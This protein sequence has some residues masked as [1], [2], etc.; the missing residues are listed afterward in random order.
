MKV[1]ST[2]LSGIVLLSGVTKV[3]SQQYVDGSGS[4]AGNTPCH[5]TIQSAITSAAAGEA[6]TVYPGTYAE[7]VTINKNITLISTGGRA[8]TTISGVQTSPAP[9]I[10]G[11]I[12]L[13]GNTTGVSIGT[14]TANGFTI[15]GVDWP[16]N[17]TDVGAIYVQ[18]P[19]TQANLSIIGNDVQAKGDNGFISEPG[20]TF[21]GFTFDNNILSGQTFLGTQPNQSCCSSACYFDNT[22]SNV[23]RSLFVLN[24]R[25]D[26]STPAATNVRFTDNSITGIAGANA[27][28]NI[29]VQIA[30]ADAIIEKNVFAGTTVS[31]S[32][33]C[34]RGTLRVRGTNVTIDCNQFNSAGLTG[35][36]AYH[37]LFDKQNSYATAISPANTLAGVAQYNNYDANPVAFYNPIGGLCPAIQ[38][39]VFVNA[40][41]AG[42][43]AACGGTLQTV[44]GSCVKPL[45]VTLVS[46]SSTVI[47][48]AVE[49]SWKTTSEVNNKYFEVERSEEGKIF[50]SLGQLEGK[51]TTNGINSYTFTDEQPNVG[52]NYYRLKQVDFDGAKTY[53]RMLAVNFY[54]SDFVSVYPNP[55]TNQVSVQFR[56]TA[57]DASMSVSNM[58]LYNQNGQM[59]KEVHSG[60]MMALPGI[61]P[62]V[63]FLEILMQD[64]Q[65]Y[66]KTLTKQ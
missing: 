29:L 26:G 35:T 53:S 55:V 20:A 32:A 43:Y 63:Y 31:M 61:T 39:A 45:P 15:I 65:A 10:A 18:G 12:L 48:N 3:F 28:G 44:T 60:K 41:T 16:T 33:F 40:T 17:V 34:N 21:T 13:T 14:N 66:R 2:F 62:G 6:V 9:S 47:N 36:G 19:G 50:K 30:A 57:T 1:V 24:P 46:F 11:T 4:C 22:S 59:L 23:A 51:G 27:N 38:N 49:L 64:G 58:R 42:S 25:A 37:I 5:I 54:G 52:V 7:N 56:K 8:A